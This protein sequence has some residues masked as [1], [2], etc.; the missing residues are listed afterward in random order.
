MDKSTSLVL[1]FNQ[2]SKDDTPLVG[3][4]SAN[5]GEMYN[6]VKV[7]IPN[8]F[9]TTAYAYRKFISENKLG[10]KIKA[11]L[12]GLDVENTKALSAA[13]KKIREMIM[14]AKISKELSDEILK[15][16]RELVKKEGQEFVAVRSSGTAEDLPEASFAGQQ[17][18]YL[19]VHGEKELI[20][21][22]KECYASLFTDRS[23]YYRRKMNISE[24]KVALAVAVQRMVFSKAAGVMFTLDV[25]NG[26][27]SVIMIEGSYGLGEYIVQGTV[28]PD[29][30]YVDKNTFKI[31]NKLISKQKT[32][33]L[34]ILK[35][36]G[37]KEEPVD[38]KMA[39]SQCLTDEEIIQLAK[40]GAEIEK[41]YNHP[42]D[43]E[44]AMDE[45]GD[46]LFIVQARFETAWSKKPEEMAS[47]SQVEEGQNE[48]EILITRMTAPDWVPA[49]QKA[50]AIIPDEG[51]MT[52]HAAIVSRELGVPCIVGTSAFG[53]KATET[54]KNG[55]MI[56]LDAKN[57][58]VYAGE[59]KSAQKEG[60]QNTQIEAAGNAEF[61]V[62]GVKIMVNL[63]EAKNAEE[64]SKLPVDGCWIIKRGICLGTDRR[65]SFI[66]DRKW[67]KPV[68]G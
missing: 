42:M 12:E 30:Y 57:G 41:H 6:S 34:K 68:Y 58:I 61:P 38:K 8:G 24:D 55:E 44:W 60:P 67:K 23:I 45:R 64:V 27:T 9:S 49:M 18:T 66:L 15:H 28:T 29:T 3:G 43:I 19:N 56:T 37:T 17:E 62:T 39:S 35:T 14:S 54:I 25:S 59:M 65:T 46:K 1:W 11:T 40:Y 22:I 33:M 53:K 52:C 48:G 51:G 13:G 63:S 16:Y 5:L 50:K 10:E 31:R 20:D 21:K 26:D 2:I 32:K 7:P 47:S 4:K 36:G